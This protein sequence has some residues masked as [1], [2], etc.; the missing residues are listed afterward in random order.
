MTATITKDCKIAK[1]E[2]DKNAA[3]GGGGKGGKGGFGGGAFKAGDV[4]EKGLENE[5]FK[6][7]DDA[8]GVFARITVADEDKGAV[9]KGQVTQILV[10]DF[11]NFGGKGKKKGGD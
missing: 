1:G 7:K 8:K 9:K 10:I 5:A 11:G 6:A 4:L 3:K 2:I